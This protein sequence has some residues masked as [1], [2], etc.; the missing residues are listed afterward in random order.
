MPRNLLKASRVLAFML[1]GAMTAGPAF[2]DRPPW[3]GGGNGGDHGQKERHDGDRDRDERPD[4][5]RG[6]RE[7]KAE[8]HFGDRHR[9]IV[10]DYYAKEFHAGKCPP[11][12]AKKHNGCLPPGLARKW[13][14]GRPLSAE[15]VRYDLPPG[16]V[17]QLGVPPESY[18]YV[19]VA[20]DILMIA[21]GTNMVVD[22]IRDLGG[23]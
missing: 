9:A 2:A 23:R 4:H 15:V 19:R 3:A 18:R 17:V 21:V 13:E 7:R 16:L 12:L 5:D 8:G 6:E 1:A 10:R 11:G 14:L 22:S 20:S